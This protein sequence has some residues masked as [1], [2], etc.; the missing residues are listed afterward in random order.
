MKSFLALALV[1]S[2]SSSFACPQIMGAWEC[3]DQDGTKS[4]VTFSQ[5]S[6]GVQTNSE[7]EIVNH[8]GQIHNF[9]INKLLL[10]VPVVAE[11]I[12][13]TVLNLVGGKI[14]FTVQSTPV[15]TANG[16]DI[17]MVIN[18]ATSGL[19]TF[20]MSFEDT[21]ILVTAKLAVNGSTM[22]IEDEV[23]VFDVVDGQASEIKED[24]KSQNTTCVRK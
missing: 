9:S 18:A 17:Q 23:K 3:S 10:A 5:I 24:S 6:G 16:A 21:K 2:A 14:P 7:G 4:S 19:S 13:A 1:L 12:P 8:D 11:V 22:T 15:C 20:L